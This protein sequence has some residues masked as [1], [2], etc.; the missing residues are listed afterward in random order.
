MDY[1]Q[2]KKYDIYITGSNAFLLSSDLA[3][4]FTGRT[5]E[6]EV[7]PFSFKEYLKYYNYKD[8]QE[9]FDKYTK[10]VVCQVRTFIKLKKKNINIYLMFLIH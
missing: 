1:M 2:K 4:L 10:K 6:I 5:F 3:T 9:A 8:I 7:Y